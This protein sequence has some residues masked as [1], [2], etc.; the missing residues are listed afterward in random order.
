MK[1]EHSVL[2]SR[3]VRFTERVV[4]L[5]QTAVVGEPDPAFQD[6]DGGYV[7]SGIVA[8]HGLCES[9]DHACPR[10]LDVLH[11]M[12]GTVAKL[13][14]AVADLPD[15]RVEVVRAVCKSWSVRRAVWRRVTAFA[16]AQTVTKPTRTATAVAVYIIVTVAATTAIANAT[17]TASTS[18]VRYRVASP[19]WLVDVVCDLMDRQRTATTISII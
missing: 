16:P 2:P 18:I 4:S 13:E 5:A 10:L 7:H 17:D 1:R 6:G 19:E 15:P 8:V 12:Y 14:R 3:L 9:L 11:G